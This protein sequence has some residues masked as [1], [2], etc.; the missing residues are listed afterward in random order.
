LAVVGTSTDGI[1][2]TQR[3]TAP[4]AITNNI[5]DVHCG[6]DGNNILVEIDDFVAISTGDGT[7]TWT[8]SSM[9]GGA[10][11]GCTS[12]NFGNTYWMVTGVVAAAESVIY[13]TTPAVST[14]AT[15]A[16]GIT[17]VLNDSAYG[18]GIWVV[19]G[20]NNFIGSNPTDPTGTWTSRDFGATTA[21]NINAVVYSSTLGMFVAVGDKGRLA[22][23]TD[24]ITWV[25]RYSDAELGIALYSVIWD[26]TN[27]YFIAT[28]SGIPIISYN[29]I[30]WERQAYLGNG[31]TLTKTLAVLNGTV[32]FM[33]TAAVNFVTH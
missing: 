33:N 4:G 27:G 30:T 11:T 12:V 17:E 25:Q 24:G 6:S 19:V 28:S 3:A 1:T 26:D 2:W 7:G 21:G 15:N 8:E 22:T 14:W 18:G 9:T 10:V 16:T 20:D 13:S 5:A 23:S 31:M 29:G 32:I